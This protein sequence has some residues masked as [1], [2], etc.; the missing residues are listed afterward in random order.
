MERIKELRKQNQLTLKRLG[1]IIGVSEST[2]SLYESGKRQPDNDILKRLADFFNVTV[3]YLLNRTNIPTPVFLTNKD[4]N[5]TSSEYESLFLMSDLDAALKQ[6]SANTY[7][8]HGSQ[9]KGSAT[10]QSSFLK[11]KYALAG[12]GKIIEL[13]QA[14]YSVLQ[15]V[16]EAIKLR[17]KKPSR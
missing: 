7:T 15:N 2:I 13:T 5:E 4:E 12:D 3:D 6:R 1:E 8:I 9:G 11:N 10:I 17:D 14:E 16:L